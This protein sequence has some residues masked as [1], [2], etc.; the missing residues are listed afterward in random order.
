MFL[1]RFDVFCDLLLNRPT[2]TWNL[3]VL[4]NKEL[5]F[6]RIKADARQHGI[7]LLTVLNCDLKHFE[8][9]DL[10]S[11]ERYFSVRPNLYVTLSSNLI[12]TNLIP[13][14]FVLPSTLIAPWFYASKLMGRIMVEFISPPECNIP[15]QG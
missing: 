14:K 9:E 15:G 6:I 5:S 11:F 3:F 8:L 7:Y 10:R 13:I 12:Q 1:P 4:Y 2:A